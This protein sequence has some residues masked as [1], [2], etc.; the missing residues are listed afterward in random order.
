MRLGTARRLVAEGRFTSV[1]RAHDFPPPQKKTKNA[2]PTPKILYIWPH[3]EL[4]HIH[5][6]VLLFLDML[7]SLAK[8]PHMPSIKQFSTSALKGDLYK[9]QKDLPRLPV[10]PLQETASRYL[11]SVQP[12]LTEAQFAETSRKVEDFISPGGLGPQ[13]Q[14]RLE[15]FAS[16]PKVPNWLAE[17]WDDYAYMSYRDPV[18][19]YVLYF[20]LHKDVN[21]VVGK[22]Q[23]LKAT[24]IA[25]Y[26]TQF[27]VEVQNETLE[28][29]VI[30]GNPYC[31]NAFRFMFN[32][33]RVPHAGADI[34]ARYDGAEHPYFVVSIDNH[35]Y[36]VYHHTKDGE[37]L[38]KAQLYK[39][40]EYITQDVKKHGRNPYPVGALT[41]LNRDEWLLLYTQLMQSP[42]NRVL[43][44][45]LH[46]LAFV[47][48]LDSNSP[49]TI[50]EK[51]ANC[52]HG[53]GQNRYFD[54]PLEFFVSANGN[55]GFLGE[56]LRMDATPTVQLNNFVVSKIFSEDPK[57]LVQEITQNSVGGV[58]QSVKELPVAAVPQIL[59]FDINPHVRSEIALAITKFNTTI[60]QHDEEVFQYQ[61]YGKNL[62][63]QFK[64]SPDAYVQMMMQLAYYKA[65]GKIRPTY[66]SAATRKFLNGRTETGRTV[67]NESKKFVETWT[68][69]DATN[70]E[71][72]ATFQAACKQHVKY[73]S[74][75][76]NGHGVDRHFLGLKN[77]LQPGEEVPAIFTDPVFS[78]SAT[79]YISSSQIPSEYFQSWG[80]SQVI[81]DGFGLAYMINS[82]W[83]HVHISCK[84]GN[85][86]RSDHLKYYLTESAN[87]MRDVLKTSL[88]P[89]AKL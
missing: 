67:S 22:D 42:L 10:P 78:Y 28:P 58:V 71:K 55:L 19:P 31:M 50:E 20:F 8:I 73:L 66:E 35:F 85:G 89:K 45:A 16:N 72:I 80:W 23:L 13:L 59:P 56:H 15:E 87:E 47:I 81:D 5:T 49:V 62:I 84:R 70:E 57:K 2:L 41:S 12:L 36:K 26:T 83:I 27:M 54:K 60:A 18:V 79:W 75:A 30:K 86:L 32:N 64:V 4:A 38:T 9:Y 51:L 68:S 44:E 63:K 53:D 7:K 37:A 76:A 25:F 29:E 24:L 65:T 77:Q 3:P 61:G 1:S 39:Q 43:L 82:E 48:C 14:A 69:F 88:P 40:F 46:A 52:W 6:P 17:T 74:D 11:L 33:L 34:T 21:N